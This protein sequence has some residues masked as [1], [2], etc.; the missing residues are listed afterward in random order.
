MGTLV[1]A[2]VAQW[3]MCGGHVL[4]LLRGLPLVLSTFISACLPPA[5]AVDSAKVS[6]NDATS[7]CGL[8]VCSV[9]E[10]W[11]AQCAYPGSGFAYPL[12]WGGYEEL[13]LTHDSEMITMVGQRAMRYPLHALYFALIA[14]GVDQADARRNLAAQLQQMARELVE[15]RNCVGYGQGQ[16]TQMWRTVAVYDT[17]RIRRDFPLATYAR[18]QHAWRH[19][20]AQHES[21]TGDHETIPGAIHCRRKPD[22]DTLRQQRQTMI[23]NAKVSLQQLMDA[24]TVDWRPL[25]RPDD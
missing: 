5:T 13:A 4:V 23:D 17:V 12:S 3:P 20:F 6:R 1:R 9:W 24:S 18:L 11:L 10:A 2:F 22:D 14:V 19:D 8:W 16:G 15:V 21:P 7:A 25:P